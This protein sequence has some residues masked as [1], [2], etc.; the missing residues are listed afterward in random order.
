MA[1]SVQ[2]LIAQHIAD[3]LRQEPRNV[4]ILARQGMLAGSRFI[5]EDQEGRMD[6]RKLRR[7]PFPDVYKQWVEH[8]KDAVARASDLD[9]LLEGSTSHYRLIRGGAVVD[10]GTDP[11]EEVVGYLFRML[12]KDDGYAAAVRAAESVT[13][14]PSF[15]NELASTFASRNLLHAAKDNASMFISHPI[16]Q[17]RELKGTSKAVYNPQFAQENSRLYIME[18]FDLSRSRPKAVRNSAGL[19]A[20]MYRDIEAARHDIEAISLIK[21]IDRADDEG[22]YMN[23]LWM[24]E[25]ESRIVD[26]SSSTERTDFLAERERIADIQ[27]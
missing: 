18:A 20:Y 19:A 9:A 13:T 7:F 14:I 5:G 27:V 8:W 25:A 21:G 26:W 15:R 2:Y 6:G 17:N 3:P 22:D 4:G 24:L 23:S 16:V 11:V 10:V 12:V 1:D